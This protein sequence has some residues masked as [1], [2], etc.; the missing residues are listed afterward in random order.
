MSSSTSYSG[1]PNRMNSN[2]S[3][4]STTR[5]KS[6]QRG[7]QSWVGGLAEVPFD[8]LDTTW[9]RDYAAGRRLTRPIEEALRHIGLARQN[10]DGV[11]RPTRAAV[12]VFA[13]DPGGLLDAKCSIRL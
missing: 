13:E 8:L 7:T 2:S 1:C 9:W 11:W 6:M 10:A 12:L 5:G 3:A 4:A